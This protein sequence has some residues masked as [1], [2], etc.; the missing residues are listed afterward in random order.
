M[1]FGHTAFLYSNFMRE[2]P[3]PN[4]A[5]GVS[6]SAAE[7]LDFAAE[8]SDSAA[9]VSDS[10]AG[11]SDF[12]A[13]VSDSAAGVLN[14]MP[15]PDTLIH[16]RF[17]ASSVVGIPVYGPVGKYQGIPRYLTKEDLTGY[18]FVDIV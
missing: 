11:V 15:S 6:D 1:G 16:E 3:V 14:H 8:V 2:E 5:A 7:V 4:F 9:E 18:V 10:A 13:G 12:A 17:E